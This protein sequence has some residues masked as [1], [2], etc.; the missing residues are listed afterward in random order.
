MTREEAIKNIKEHCYF[1]NLIPQAKEALNVAIKALEQER[2]ANIITFVKSNTF[3]N[4][5]VKKDSI[6]GFDKIGNEY[7]IFLNG[8]GYIDVRAG[9]Y[10]YEQLI[11]VMEGENTSDTLEFDLEQ[12]KSN[13]NASALKGENK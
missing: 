13:I 5:A 3:N 7:R 11:K 10:E 9:H 2:S 12:A 4:V 8:G 6:I 1:A